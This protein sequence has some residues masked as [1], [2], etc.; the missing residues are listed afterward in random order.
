MYRL[1]HGDTLVAGSQ[2]VDAK[3]GHDSLRLLRGLNI[4]LHPATIG[5]LVESAGGSGQ[6]LQ[7]GSRQLHAFLLPFRADREPVD[8]ATLDKNL[9]LEPLGLQEKPLKILIAKKFCLL[10]AIVPNAGEHVEEILIRIADP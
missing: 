1:L 8:A 2:S 6:R 5:Q 3:V 9:G 4:Q 10:W 7:V